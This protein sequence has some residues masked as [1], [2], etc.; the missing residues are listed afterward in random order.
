MNV[1]SPTDEHH[2]EHFDILIVG[3]GISG[4]DAAYHLGQHRPDA[5]YAILE[6]KSGLGG[7]WATHTFP[8]IRSD[9]DLFTFGFSWKPW[10]GV[11]IATADEILSYLEEAVDE[12][13]IRGNI[14]FNHHIE[15]AQW[16]S[17][18]QRWVLTATRGDG[19]SFQISCG[20]LWSC[21]GYFK[22]DEGY[23]PEWPG[24]ADF[25]GR[26][27]HP[28][29]WPDDLDYAGQRV[30]VIGSGATAATIIPAMA[31][32]AAHIT[33]VQR[34]PTFYY[35]KV[36]D[37][38]FST[39]LRALNLPDEWFHEIMRRKYLHDSQ[40]TA[41]RAKSEPEVLAAELIEAARTY[42]GEDYDI[43]THFTP[44]YRPWR[45]RVAMIP[46]GDFYVAIREGKAEVV[47][48]H[49]DQLTTNGLRLTDGREVEVD[50]IVAATGLTLNVFGDIQ[51]VV[52]G[53]VFDAAD[54]VTHRGVMFTGL[55][56]FATVFGY[57]RSSWT[58]RADLVSQY[59]CRVFDHM[60][61]EGVG[62]V[63]PVLPDDE[64]E[65]RPWVEPENFNAGYL[66]RSLG[67]LPRQGDRQ[68]WL[69]TQ[70]YFQDRDDLPA[71]ALDDGTLAF[72]LRC[73]V[74]KPR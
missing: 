71:A 52:D 46:D 67:Q 23:M 39:I 53:E 65:R 5:S 59:L 51:L 49:I 50:L 4:I 55:P 37:D 25:K 31:D 72:R 11:A 40:N 54:S 35:P 64:M 12:N 9:S 58:L 18:T 32:R 47:T 27:V 62:V 8:G 33:M 20:F 1:N 26:I 7:T 15:S 45:Q 24:M 61:A 17:E 63:V 60:D 22:H 28:Q 6:S 3:A 66:T 2:I 48:A 19:V 34:S 56:N 10:K 42:L 36:M 38:E 16:S 74:A 57:L 14:R 41:N 43:A 21:A 29:T 70:D 68:P 44:T 73:A 13:D 30:A 69:L